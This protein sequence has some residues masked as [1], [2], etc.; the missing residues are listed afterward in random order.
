M[1]CQKRKKIDMYLKKG[2]LFPASTA[3]SA[4]TGTETNKDP[5][6][7]KDSVAHYLSYAVLMT[8]LSVLEAEQF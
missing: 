7:K 4:L 6:T 1:F 5:F 3:S 2:D 8:Y